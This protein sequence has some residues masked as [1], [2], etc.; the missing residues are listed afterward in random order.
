MCGINGIYAAE[1][2]D[3]RDIDY[4]KSMNFNCRHR[5]PD[6]EGLF[7][8]NQIVLGHRRLAIID[9]TEAGN[10]PMASFDKRFQVVYNGAIY[11]YE[12]IKAQLSSYSFFSK[13]DTEVVLAAYSTWGIESLNHFNGMF[14]FAV[15]DSFKKELFIARDR[16]GIKPLYYYSSS[17]MFFFSSELRGLLILD[18]IKPQIKYESLVN[19][20]RYQTVHAPN[21]MIDGIQMLQPG[22]FLSISH[23]GLQI[24]PYWNLKTKNRLLP[25]K[26]NH[27]EIVSTVRSKL[28]K[29]VEKRLISD[30][31]F[32]AFLSGGI[33][34]SAIVALM[35]SISTATVNTFSLTFENT[36]FDE[37][38]YSKLV[39]KKYKTNHFELKLFPNDLLELIPRALYAMDHPSGDGINTYVISRAAKQA[40]IKMALSGLGSDELFAGYDVFRRMYRLSWIELLNIIPKPIRSIIGRILLFSRK[41]IPTKKMASLLKAESIDFMSI[42][43]LTRQTFFDDQIWRLLKIQKEVEESV[44]AIT[45]KI[46][47][48]YGMNYKVSATSV[49]EIYTYLQNILLRDTD[50]MSMAHSLEVRVPFLDHE[51]VEFVVSLPD[52]YKHPSLSKKL[53]TDAIGD[54]LPEKIINRPKMGFLFPWEQWL[55][56]ELFDIAQTSINNLSQ[57]EMFNSKAVID[58]WNRF[59]VNDPQ[60]GWSRVWPLIVLENWMEAID[61]Q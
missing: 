33:D 29:S 2:I 56:N 10:Q 8:D 34:S 42:Y 12:E 25:I 23:K 19:Y 35:C 31:P 47:D 45:F 54:L 61:I 20:L 1:G 50:Q 55:K 26:M 4:V 58:L 53:L 59:K 24:T 60:T 30:V 9:P 38:Q 27:N 46:Q 15:W 37:S 39:A 7:I 13:T 51:L 6:N 36:L 52:I 43:S 11:N 22:H 44:S 21:T 40:G 57:R 14:A 16:L 49:A 3:E 28:I 17:N 18:I 48:I 41:S 5:G 32:G